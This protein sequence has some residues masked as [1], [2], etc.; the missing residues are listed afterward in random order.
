MTLRRIFALATSLTIFL[1]VANGAHAGCSLARVSGTDRAVPE[2]RL[3]QKLLDAAILAQVN[4]ERCRHGL[5]RLKASSGLRREATGHSK[6]MGRAQ[7]L[8]HN[9]TTSGRQTVRQRL[10]RSGIKLHA[11]SENIGMFHFYQLDGRPFLVRSD[12]ACHFTTHAGQDLPRHS[13]D[14]LATMAVAY[15]MAS[16]HH[17]VN[18][19]DTK[20][21]HMGSGTYINVQGEYCGTVFMAQNFVG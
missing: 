20:V 11:G 18:I 10:K 5:P 3:N 21:S 15:W 16:P 12:A 4:Y 7:N 17:R 13:Y 8:S 6:W 9:S 19:L 14:S 1:A 2:T